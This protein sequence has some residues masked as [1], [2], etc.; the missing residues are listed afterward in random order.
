MQSVLVIRKHPT[1]QKL[2]LS[3]RTQRKRGRFDYNNF[4]IVTKKMAR[5]IVA[6]SDGRIKCD[7]GVVLSSHGVSA[8]KIRVT[9]ERG[10]SPSRT[11]WVLYAAPVDSEGRVTEGSSGTKMLGSLCGEDYTLLR[12][13]YGVQSKL[14]PSGDDREEIARQIR[15]AGAHILLLTEHMAAINTAETNWYRQA[16]QD[17]ADQ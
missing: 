17:A 2:I 5:S 1:T 6:G 12:R 7:E 16:Q 3:L 14:D 13:H 10:L 4:F 9:L 15:D 8:L 11:P